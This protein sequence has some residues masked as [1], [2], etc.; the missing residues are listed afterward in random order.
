MRLKFNLPV[1]RSEPS[2]SHRGER[3]QLL[4]FLIGREHAEPGPDS[5][6]P[7]N[8]KPF[9]PRQNPRTCPTPRRAAGDMRQRP[10]TTLPTSTGLERKPRLA[11]G[12]ILPRTAAP[13]MV[14][15]LT[16]VAHSAPPDELLAEAAETTMAMPKLVDL[17]LIDGTYQDR[18]ALVDTSVAQLLAAAH[19]TTLG[20]AEYHRECIDREC[21]HMDRLFDELF[22]PTPP[23]IPQFEDIKVPFASGRRRGPLAIGQETAK[24]AAMLP[25]APARHA[26]PGGAK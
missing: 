23:R 20:A 6:P 17:D 8:Y 12:R 2:G 1:H 5:A 11:V 26:L 19:A 15:G 16:P 18:L 14:P 24:L 22:P 10:Y 7:A 9:E 21:E 3:R 4:A 25:A 13:T